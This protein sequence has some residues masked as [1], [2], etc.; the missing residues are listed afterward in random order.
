[1]FP[2]YTYDE[3]KASKDSKNDMYTKGKQ[4]FFAT[5][6]YGGTY[7]TLMNKLG[8]SAGWVGP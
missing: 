2:E 8:V 3:I 5:I 6:L 1:M 4:G 7:Q